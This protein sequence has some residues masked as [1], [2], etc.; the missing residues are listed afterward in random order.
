MADKL[1]GDAW[2]TYDDHV[3]DDRGRGRGGYRYRYYE[4]YYESEEYLDLDEFKA[5]DQ[6][7]AVWAEAC[8]ALSIQ[9]ALS[10]DDAEMVDDAGE[11]AEGVVNDMDE[12]LIGEGWS[13]FYLVYIALKERWDV[14][15]FQR[16]LS[17]QITKPDDWDE[18]ASDYAEQVD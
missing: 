9:D 18:N 6:L 5:L 15:N 10:P 3:S 1:S 8:L 13:G 16:L 12:E 2:S 4:S 17:G 11:S 7:D 14:S